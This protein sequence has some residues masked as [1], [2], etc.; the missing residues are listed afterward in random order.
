MIGILNNCR[1][2][3]S[4]KDLVDLLS[5]GK[6]TAYKL[7]NSG[8]I[9]SKIIGGK[10]KILKEWVIEFLENIENNISVIDAD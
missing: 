4:I 9:R 1:D 6:N 8:K 7:V 3:L 2:V 10:H 5:I